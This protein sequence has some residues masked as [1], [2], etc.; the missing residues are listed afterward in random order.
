MYG[1]RGDG[2]SLDRE[3]GI[4][5]AGYWMLDA[6]QEWGVGYWIVP[7]NHTDR[8]LKQYYPANWLSGPLV[9]RFNRG[10]RI[11]IPNGENQMR[12]NSPA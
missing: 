7:G 11:H 3:C 2:R 9:R 10:C 1:C 12:K 4:L 6:D 5:D 8:T